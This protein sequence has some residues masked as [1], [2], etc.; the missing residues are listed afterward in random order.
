MATT[1][2]FELAVCCAEPPKAA[3]TSSSSASGPVSHDWLYRQ[4]PLIICTDCESLWCIKQGVTTPKET[5]LLPD[6]SQLRE[7]DLLG[8]VRGSYWVATK[9][10]VA[11]GLTKV[12]PELKPPLRAI[13]QGT[14]NPQGYVAAPDAAQRKSAAIVN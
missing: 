12:S 14:W 3:Q 1:V 9:H 4:H 5:N 7:A 8:H 10:M 6:I 2:R 13:A 11:D